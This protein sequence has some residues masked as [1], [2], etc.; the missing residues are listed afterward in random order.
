MNGADFIIAINLTVAGS[1]AAA[2]LALGVFGE[3]RE[4]AHAFAFCYGLGALNFLLEF[5]L[6][7]LGGLFLVGFGAYAAF[8]AAVSVFNLGLARLYERPA[9]WLAIAVLFVGG[10]VTRI[11][12]EA[13]A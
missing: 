5:M 6:P 10:C 12:I 7:R 8:L 1:L 13:M 11:A 4:A 2:F 9:P 3:R